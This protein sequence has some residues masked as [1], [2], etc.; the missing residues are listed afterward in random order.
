MHWDCFTSSSPV[1]QQLLFK[2]SFHFQDAKSLHF[3]H[4]YISPS[5]V[6]MQKA[7]KSQ[8]LYLQARLYAMV[9]CWHNLPYCGSPSQ[10]K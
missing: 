3:T 6:A 7:F 4:T 2:R 5:L 10:V 9:H 1:A 8:E